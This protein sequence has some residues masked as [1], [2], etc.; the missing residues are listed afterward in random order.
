M[1]NL[2]HFQGKMVHFFFKNEAL[3]SES[4]NTLFHTKKIILTYILINSILYK[5]KIILKYKNYFILFFKINNYIPSYSLPCRRN[6]QC[7]SI[8]R[9]K[10]YPSCMS[11]TQNNSHFL[12]HVL[13]SCRS[14]CILN[15]ISSFYSGT[16]IFQKMS[17]PPF[18][19]WISEILNQPQNYCVQKKNGHFKISLNILII[20]LK[21]I[22]L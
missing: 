10:I 12:F 3:R 4:V 17:F 11:G 22:L 5:G 18:L 1:L 9:Y 15:L 14:L 20:S 13:S 2:M 8:Y 21:V 6:P 16:T 7:P 19:I